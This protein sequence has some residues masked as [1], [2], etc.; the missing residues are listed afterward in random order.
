MEKQEWK[1]QRVREE[2]KDKVY[3]GDDRLRS[4]RS[5]NNTKADCGRGWQN[6]KNLRLYIK[7]FTA[8]GWFSVAAGEETLK[9]QILDRSAREE[10]EEAEVTGAGR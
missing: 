4:T 1:R 6:S 2:R 8:L 5:V 7:G 9:E 3:E 10:R